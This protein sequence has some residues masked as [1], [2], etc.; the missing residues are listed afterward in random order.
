MKPNQ[1]GIIPDNGYYKD[2]NQSLIAIKVLRWIEHK[3][4]L[5]IQTRQSAEGEYR[6]RV[7]DGSLLRLDGFIKE[8]NIAIEFLGCAW[9]GHEW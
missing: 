1:I 7:S 6:L 3:T 5:Q 2:T 9:H 8:K 4:G